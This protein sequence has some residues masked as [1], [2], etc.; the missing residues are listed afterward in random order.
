M[1][2]KSLTNVFQIIILKV[3]ISQI[4]TFFLFLERCRSESPGFERSIPAWA[5]TRGSLRRVERSRPKLDM[6]NTDSEKK[7]NFLTSLRSMRNENGNTEMVV[8]LH[9]YIS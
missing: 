6:E 4:D 2:L 5:N 1:I 3:C 9:R 8:I 7:T